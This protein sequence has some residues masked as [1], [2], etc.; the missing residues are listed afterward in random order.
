MDNQGFSSLAIGNYA[1]KTNQAANSIIL[2]ATGG[3]LD[4]V[5]GQTGSFYVAPIRKD[6]TITTPLFYDPATHE[7]VYG[8]T[9]VGGPEVP[10][11]PEVSPGIGLLSGITFCGLNFVTGSGGL[12]D[13]N[14]PPYVEIEIAGLKSTSNVQV[15]AKIDPIYLEDTYPTCSIL[16]TELDTDKLWVYVTSNPNTAGYGIMWNVV[17][18]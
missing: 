8:T 4:G 1:G 3:D 18:F 9:G 7:I 12:D 14:A 11:G 6:L 5:S 13:P 2:N 16:F 17:S 15:T 10:V